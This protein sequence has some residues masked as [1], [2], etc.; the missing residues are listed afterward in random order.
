MPVRFGPGF[1]A[2]FGDLAGGHLGKAGE[3]VAQVGQRI[4]AASAAALEDG[5]ED[6]SALAGVGGS[7]RRIF[8]LAAAMEGVIRV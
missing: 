6:G 3:H 2:D 1:G 7:D 8:E 5:V 4:D